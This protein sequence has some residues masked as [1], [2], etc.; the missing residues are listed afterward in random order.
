MNNNSNNNFGN[1][2]QFGNTPFGNNQNALSTRSSLNS[3]RPA[4][5]S[6]GS[7][8]GRPSSFGSPYGRPSSFGSS[9]GGRPMSSFG[10][11]YGRPMSF[12][13]SF[14]NQRP[15]S[16][17]SYSRPFGGAGM[18]RP[19]F[20]GFSQ[21]GSMYRPSY[22]STMPPY[23]SAY[24][25]KFGPA[26]DSRFGGAL[27]PYTVGNPNAAPQDQPPADA[28]NKY[29]LENAQPQ[30]VDVHNN[31]EQVGPELQVQSMYGDVYQEQQPVAAALV[32]PTM[33]PPQEAVAAAPVEEHVEHA[34]YHDPGAELDVEFIKSWQP[35][36]KE[37]AEFSSY[38]VDKRAAYIVDNGGNVVGEGYEGMQEDPNNPE[39]E[40]Y[41]YSAEINAINNAYAIGKETLI[42]GASIISIDLPSE[43]TVTYLTQMGIKTIFFFVPGEKGIKKINKNKV[44]KAVLDIAEAAGCKL[45]PVA[46]EK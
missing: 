29:S 31:F 15:G 36:V 45:V 13:S 30:G 18:S 23:G 12:G 2:P 9:Y 3:F 38:G 7:S 44:Y 1:P 17:G 42:Y 14:G 19:P 24:A 34:E 4:Y 6:F 22:M 10:S 26:P 40:V 41:E 21:P 16:F 11:S 35:S 43:D 39:A 27:P 33:M 28:Y 5:G 25:S 8:Y 32:D 37:L 20:S 46:G